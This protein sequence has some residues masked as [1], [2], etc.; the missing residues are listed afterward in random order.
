METYL[1]THNLES[2]VNEVLNVCLRERPED[3]F[4]KISLLLKEKSR[5]G[6]TIKTVKPRI[7]KD[8]KGGEACEILIG[9]EHY[10]EDAQIV[11]A[12]ENSDVIGDKYKECV[13]TKI[14]KALIDK[15]PTDQNEID[16][17]LL[18]VDS[19]ENKLN[20]GAH[21]LFLASIASCKVGA[22][23]KG[24]SAYKHLG[25]LFGRREFALPVPWVHLVSLEDVGLGM[26]PVGAE[27]FREAIDL[28]EQVV[29]LIH[30]PASDTNEPRILTNVTDAFGSICDMLDTA[31]MKGLVK[32]TFKRTPVACTFSQ[33]EEQTET[34]EP[35]ADEPGVDFQELLDVLRA[36]VTDEK[37]GE[38]LGMIVNFFPD[39]EAEKLKAF[40]EEFG[41]SIAIVNEANGDE[42]YNS[43]IV[44][45]DRPFKDAC[46]VSE[47]NKL[48]EKIHTQEHALIAD[49][50]KQTS[51]WSE[52]IADYAIALGAGVMNFENLFENG[53]FKIINR[54]LGIEEELD[55][56]GFYAGSRFRNLF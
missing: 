15:D 56:D 33:D 46:T 6:K 17:A 48:C 42:C 34:I 27:T 50:D 21:T 5:A 18:M 39:G 2:V 51:C 10:T 24:V 8:C 12:H 3:P 23:T 1:E 26:L 28:C 25:Q 52:F 43:N 11:M 35:P 36:L 31:G 22:K 47:F 53:N 29:A 38:M 32:L 7:I 14:A 9:T 40:L 55:M 45:L 30:Q 19:S 16:A 4:A 20:A 44:S 54:I 41:E 49:F 13:S 37:N